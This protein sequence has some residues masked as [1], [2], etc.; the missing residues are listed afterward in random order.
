MATDLLVVLEDRPGEMARV[1]ET[2]GGAG[3]NIAGFCATTE[4]GRGA[5]HLLVE[6]GADDPVAVDRNRERPRDGDRRQRNRAADARL[7]AEHSSRRP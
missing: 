3:V 7:V 6:D 5:V 1:G 4:G 2:L